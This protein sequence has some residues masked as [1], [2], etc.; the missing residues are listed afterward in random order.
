[1]ETGASH[2]LAFF[3][4]NLRSRCLLIKGLHEVGIHI[5]AYM[6]QIFGYKITYNIN[7]ETC[8][9][10]VIR[11]MVRCAYIA[12]NKKRNETRTN[13]QRIKHGYRTK[14]LFYESEN[15]HSETVGRALWRN[16]P[17]TSIVA[18]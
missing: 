9:E 13:K 11:S 3:S 2:L 14:S 1:M 4:D 15:M 10:K 18:L 12:A 6:W 7:V 17:L 5:Y 8:L 16:N